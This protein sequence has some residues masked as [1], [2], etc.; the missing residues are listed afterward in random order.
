[1]ATAGGVGEGGEGPVPAPP[2]EARDRGDFYSDT[3]SARLCLVMV[4]CARSAPPSAA[5]PSLPRRSD[6]GIA[7][8]ATEAEPERG[9][10]GVSERP[11]PGLRKRRADSAPAAVPGGRGTRRRGPGCL[12]VP[13]V[14]RKAR[15]ARLE[16]HPFV[17]R[18]DS[19]GGPGTTLAG[20]EAQGAPLRRRLGD[21]RALGGL[22]CALGL[23]VKRPRWGCFLPFSR[24]RWRLRRGMRSPPPSA[25]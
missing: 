5:P 12:G 24:P 10:G 8:W 14:P 19:R 23:A 4:T 16:F 11:A 13:V 6:G 7:A 2:L 15:R 9:H 20:R 18:R 22:I 25:S 1:M 21:P 3:A 17:G